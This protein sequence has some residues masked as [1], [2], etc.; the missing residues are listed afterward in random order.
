[1][2]NLF[3]F[4]LFKSYLQFSKNYFCEASRKLNVIKYNVIMF[5]MCV[6]VCVIVLNFD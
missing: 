3:T 4:I 1:M 2:W 5:Q 6:C